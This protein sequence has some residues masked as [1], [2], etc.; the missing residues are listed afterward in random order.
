MKS[1]SVKQNKTPNFSLP[2]PHEKG[3]PPP[4]LT[5]E[6][7]RQRRVSPKS[8]KELNRE[9]LAEPRQFPLEQ[10]L[11][12]TELE[13]DFRGKLSVVGNKLGKPEMEASKTQST[14]H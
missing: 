14:R 3:Y 1:F 7:T 4:L 10:I 9:G 11:L 5:N 8:R 6:G 13:G 12:L 2:T